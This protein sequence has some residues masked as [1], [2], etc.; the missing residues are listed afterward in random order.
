METVMYVYEIVKRILEKLLTS[1]GELQKKLIT[2]EYKN[3]MVALNNAKT[4]S[5]LLIT[6]KAIESFDATIKLAGSPAWA[7]TDL[8]FLIAKWNRQYRLWKLRG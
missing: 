4:L 1:N 7:K 6:K 2:D 5:H 8:T 3:I